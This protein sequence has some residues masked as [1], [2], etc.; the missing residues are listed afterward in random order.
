MVDS[1]SI[2]PSFLSPPF[3]LPPYY[4]MGPSD[5]F[6]LPA[7]AIMRQSLYVRGTR[8]RAKAWGSVLSA[9]RT[10]QTV[11]PRK[12]R[13][14]AP[15]RQR[16]DGA[17]EDCHGIARLV[18]SLLGFTATPLSREMP[19]S[20]P[21]LLA[22]TSA[23]LMP[24]FEYRRVQHQVPVR[25][26]QHAL[27]QSSNYL[28]ARQRI[29]GSPLAS[30]PTSPKQRKGGRDPAW[31]RHCVTRTAEIERGFLQRLCLI[32]LLRNS[33]QHPCGQVTMLVRN[34][35]PRLRLTYTGSSPFGDSFPVCKAQSTSSGTFA[36]N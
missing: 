6:A 35:T 10:R 25:K 3:L 29:P 31:R 5:G 32:S 30:Q 20:R 34:G 1:V 17:A 28:I 4:L 27:V 11:K 12:R 13:R 15:C 33:K 2:T 7:T 18:I 21:C 36:R 16:V 8:A 23:S 22:S 9:K 14:L 24:T 19:N 26:C